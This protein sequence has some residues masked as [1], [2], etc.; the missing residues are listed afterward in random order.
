MRNRY[1][2]EGEKMCKVHVHKAHIHIHINTTSTYHTRSC[3]TYTHMHT[4]HY[5][6]PQPGTLLFAHGLKNLPKHLQ[7][8][9]SA[10]AV[11]RSRDQLP[12][13]IPAPPGDIGRPAP[14]PPPPTQLV[15]REKGPQL[16]YISEHDLQLGAELGQGEFGS[17]LKGVYKG[18]DGKKVRRAL[19]WWH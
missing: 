8:H 6:Q 5:S 10:S 13:P 7:S 12:F 19:R 9:L 11:P 15:A 3:I 16:S 14:P 17:V 2:E 4:T 1:R 18:A